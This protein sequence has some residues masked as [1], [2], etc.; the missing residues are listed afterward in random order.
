MGYLPLDQAGAIGIVLNEQATD[1]TYT[2]ARLLEGFPADKSGIKPGDAIVAVRGKKPVS[3]DDAYALFFGKKDEPIEFSYKRDSVTQT[4]TL[5]RAS[6]EKPK[7][8]E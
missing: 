8:P 1:G 3:V 4:V 5:V 6:R 2:V 7:Q